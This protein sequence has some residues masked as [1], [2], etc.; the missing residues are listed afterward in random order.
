MKVLFSCVENSCRSQIA[1]ALAK[2]FTNQGIDFLSGGSE[3]SGV[4][5]PMAIKLLRSEGINLISHK[6]KNVSEFENI[7]IDYLISMGCGDLCP[8]VLANKR[9]EWNIPDPKNMNESEFQDVI[10]NIRG[11]VLRLIDTIYNEHSL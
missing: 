7:K 8:N 3:P 9:I 10:E 2:K 5:N 4:V 1:E 6:S 11:K